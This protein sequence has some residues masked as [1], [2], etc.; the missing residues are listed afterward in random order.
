M[1][2][3]YELSEEDEQAVSAFMER[4]TLLPGTTPPLRQPMQLWW[5]AQLLQRWD[6]QRRAQVPLDV[7]E[8]L[9]VVA[10]LVAAAVLV[11]WAAPT[12]MRF[13]AEPLRQLLG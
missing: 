7:V 12:L 9:E 8:R 3:W 13:V 5:K 6:A 11:G 2:R 10:G 4:V 1:K